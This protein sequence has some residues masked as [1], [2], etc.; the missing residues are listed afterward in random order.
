MTENREKL[1]VPFNKPIIEMH[2]I[3]VSDIEKGYFS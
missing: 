1:M 2:Y 3:V